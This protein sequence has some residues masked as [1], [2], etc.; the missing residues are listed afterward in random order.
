MSAHG[1]TKAPCADV[2]DLGKFK[3]NKH[4][5]KLREFKKRQSPGNSKSKAQGIQKARLW[6]SKVK[7]HLDNYTHMKY[8]IFIKGHGRTVSLVL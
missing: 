6:S 1:L 7:K 5:S 8:N 4:N 2:L 3:F